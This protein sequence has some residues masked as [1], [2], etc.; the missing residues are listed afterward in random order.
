MAH[1]HTVIEPMSTRVMLAT[2]SLAIEETRLLREIESLNQQLFSV[3]SN[4]SGC[5]RMYYLEQQLNQLKLQLLEVRE[6][7]GGYDDYPV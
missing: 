7:A 3:L 4:S 2:L 1:L 6:K 5:T